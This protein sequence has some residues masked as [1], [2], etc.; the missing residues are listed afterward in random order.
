MQDPIRE[1]VQF[2]NWLTNSRTGHF[3]W[4]SSR[5]VCF[6][7]H[8][9]FW[10]CQFVKCTYSS[11]TVDDHHKYKMRTRTV[12]ELY[13]QFANCFCIIRELFYFLVPSQI[14]IYTYTIRE[15]V[16]HSSRIVHTVREL[17]KK[18]EPVRELCLTS[19]RTD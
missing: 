19:S 10:S 14:A 18:Y 13:V 16:T 17:Y 2:A 7:H 9:V 1:L 4:H 8:F 12:R 11:R 3:I 5:T 6:F 15:L